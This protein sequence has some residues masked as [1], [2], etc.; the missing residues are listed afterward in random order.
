MIAI[1]HLPASACVCTHQTVAAKSDSK[2][3]TFYCDIVPV[4]HYFGCSAEPRD[5][6]R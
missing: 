2:A 6:I 4:R 1:P 5:T 3:P